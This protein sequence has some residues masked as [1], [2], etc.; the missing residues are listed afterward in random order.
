V[1]AY[2][3]QVRLLPEFD[4]P[5]NR[6]ENAP[7]A[8]WRLQAAGSVAVYAPLIFLNLCPGYRNQPISRFLRVGIHYVERV[9]AVAWPAPDR[10]REDRTHLGLEKATPGSGPCSGATR[11]AAPSLR[12]SRL[13]RIDFPPIL[14]IYVCCTRK[15]RSCSPKYSR[16]VEARIVFGPFPLR[17]G[18]VCGRAEVLA[19]DS[20]LMV[21]LG[22]V[23]RPTS[24]LSVWPLPTD[25]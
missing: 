11:R 5:E 10:R 20:D 21:D 1:D 12:S 18:L 8:G 15:H 4:R 24:P 19:N 14:N 2:S 9:G 25:Y 6:C 23:E 7:R 22:G 16:C 17:N 3:L 13:V